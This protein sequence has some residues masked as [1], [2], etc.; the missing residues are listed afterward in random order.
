MKPIVTSYRYRYRYRLAS[1]KDPLS[2]RPK[3]PK[4]VPLALYYLT[5]V[6]LC[7]QLRSST[8]RYQGMYIEG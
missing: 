4:F 6:L 2:P 1:L 7:R 5:T 8:S 3:L